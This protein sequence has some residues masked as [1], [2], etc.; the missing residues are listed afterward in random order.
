[1]KLTFSL[2]LKTVFWT[3]CLKPLP[4]VVDPAPD[5]AIV[6][7]DVTVYSM[8]FTFHWKLSADLRIE[9]EHTLNLFSASE[10]AMDITRL[11]TSLS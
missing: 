4:P 5:S 3:T 8:S 7:P 6:A 9:Q 2:V 10:A 11:E 1:M